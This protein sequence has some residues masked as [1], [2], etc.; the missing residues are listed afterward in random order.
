M[1]TA[2]AEFNFGRLRYDW[3][4]KRVQPFVEGLERV[5]RLAERSPGF[6]WRMLD[7]EMEAAQ[8]GPTLSD[9]RVASTL[10]VW[11]S[12]EDLRKFVFD[13]LHGSFLK[14]GSEWFE[15]SDSPRYVIWPVNPD[16]RPSVEEGLEKIRHLEKH[17][18]SATCFD[19]RWFDETRESVGTM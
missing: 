12:V 6:I 9:D 17:G 15:E 14:R 19:F 8:L 2:I 16:H 13:T 7:D 18:A 1:S 4:D 5:N 3:T 10:S 11:R